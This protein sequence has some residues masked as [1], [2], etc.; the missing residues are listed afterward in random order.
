MADRIEQQLGNYRLVRLIGVGSFGEV[1]VG[2][3]VYLS[4]LAA[5]KVLHLR[6]AAANQ[7]A[8]LLEA[9]TVAGLVHPHI[10]RILDYGVDEKTP[11]LVMDYARNGTLRQRYRRGTVLPLTLVVSYIR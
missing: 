11:F 8:F 1:Y 9:R 4:T 6:L 10:V 5:I 3:H 7:E 2:E